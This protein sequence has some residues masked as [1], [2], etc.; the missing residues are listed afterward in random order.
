MLGQHPGHV[1]GHIAVANDGDLL[2]GQRPFTR[3]VRVAVV[4][5]DEVGAAVRTFQ[6]DAGDVQ[7]RVLD[8]A[9]GEDHGVVVLLQVLQHQVSAVFN[10]AEEADVA[11]VQH[12]VQGVHNALDARMVRC[13]A[14]ADQAVRRRVA[15]EEVNADHQ[16]GSHF[17]AFRQHVCCI[18]TRGA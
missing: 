15:V 17:F 1:K 8:G 3:H 2:G 12:L 18:N 9:S 16:A 4:P 7:V 6:L 13:N 11:A 5:G 10:V 14:V